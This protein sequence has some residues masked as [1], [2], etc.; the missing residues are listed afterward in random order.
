MRALTISLVIATAV[1]SLHSLPNYLAYF[2]ELSGGRDSG[3]VHLL[4]SNLDWGQNLNSIR[5]LQES[6]KIPSKNL[7]V[8]CDCGYRPSDIGVGSDTRELNQAKLSSHDTYFLVDSTTISLIRN[9]LY[10]NRMPTGLL[11]QS[12]EIPR[13]E[14]KFF[15]S[16][17][18]FSY[19]THQ[20][21][22]TSVD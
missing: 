13:A 1:S 6:G 3:A 4:H 8:F 22:Q 15:G 10:S 18:L 21:D 20:S 19:E 16:L 14:A 11:Q 7:Y 17:E 5:Q 12:G 2:N 9:G